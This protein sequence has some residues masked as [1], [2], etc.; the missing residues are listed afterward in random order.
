MGHKLQLLVIHCTATP[1][2]R[3]IYPADIHNWHTWPLEQN[4]K[5]IYMGKTYNSDAELPENVRGK[6]GRGWRQVGY[7]DM[8][9]LSGSLVNLVKY[10][11]DDVV[12]SW[13]LTNGASGINPISRHIVYVGGTD[14][15]A[16]TKDTR[17][18]AQLDALKS[19]VQN[20]LTMYPRCRVAGHNQFAKKDCPSFDVPKWLES[21]KVNEKNIYRG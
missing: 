3:H 5:L 10:N 7:S 18:K 6:R 4:G 13:E 14:K 12:D 2:G 9:M 20:F 11:D 16:K 8:I 21:I 1:E 15:N 17:T 19:Y